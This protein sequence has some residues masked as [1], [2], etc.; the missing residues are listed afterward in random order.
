VYDGWRVLEELTATQSSPFTLQ[1]SYTRG[2][3]LSGTLEGAG[4]IGG[5]L[6]LTRDP[7]GSATSAYYFHDGNGNVSTLVSA[8]DALVASYTYTPFGGTLT[9]AGSWAPVNAYR[10]S[11]K[12]CDAFTGLYYY[13]FRYYNPGT[14]RWLSR[15]P[16]GERA[17]PNLY[18]FVNGDPLNMW[19]VL[20]LFGDGRK[21]GPEH[22]ANS[23]YM[24]HSDFSGSDEF[25]YVKEDHSWNSSPLPWP[26]GEGIPGSPYAHFQD[27]T[28]SLQQVRDAIS[29]CDKEDFERKMH[30]MQ[31][32]EAHYKKDY[33]FDLTAFFG[34]WVSGAFLD[35]V[36]DSPAASA[37]GKAMR[38]SL[39]HAA[40]GLTPDQ[41]SDAW[42]RSEVRTQEMLGEWNS[43]CCKCRDKWNLRSIGPCSK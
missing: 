29:K 35:Y 12:E 1:S 7:A 17:S 2:L 39:G 40:D 10:F 23:K 31:D 38:N 30:R 43:H 37:H 18:G 22:D 34:H 19:D 36:G 41:D 13:G 26:F 15:E 33:R 8:S 24:G 32:Y 42:G 4:G 9:A 6:A 21:Y 14:G 3:D 25:D 11:A 27:L 20:G 5:L 16:L 28:T